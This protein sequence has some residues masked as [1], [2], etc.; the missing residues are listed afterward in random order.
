MV[1]NLLYLIYYNVTHHFLPSRIS[2]YILKKI[3]PD[4]K[5][6]AAVNQDRLKPGKQAYPVDKNGCEIDTDKDGV[7]DSKDYCPHNTPAALSQGVAINGC[8]KH[9]DFD[10]TPDYR[11]KCPGTPRGVRTDKH[12][13]PV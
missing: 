4:F 7:V 2:I 10:G 3:S 8:P 13:C 9:S 6:A 5:Y 1:D 11:D 12:G